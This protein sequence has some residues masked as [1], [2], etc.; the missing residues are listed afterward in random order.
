MSFSCREVIDIHAHILPGIDDGPATMEQSLALGRCYAGLGIA[1]VI[2]TS[3]F[4]PGTAWAASREIVRQKMAMV[5]ECFDSNALDVT[6]LPGM[7]IAFHRKLAERLENG[8]VLALAGSNRFLVEPSFSDGVDELLDTL[9]ILTGRGYGII[10]AHP[11]R[12]PAIQEMVEAVGAFVLEHGVEIQLNAGSLL[13]KFGSDSRRTAL[14]FIDRGCV[15]YLGSDAHGA[16]ARRP[17]DEAAWLELERI[18][19]CE[20][21]RQWCCDNP[22]ALLAGE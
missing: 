5:Q 17:P 1:R 12:I 11:E 14:R 9:G 13:G 7:E 21:L 2:C 8:Q 4:I 19:G 6:L 3:H 16:V 10:L 18:A 15:Q 20:R 22:A